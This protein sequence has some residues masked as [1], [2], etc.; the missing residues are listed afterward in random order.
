M[1]LH[2]KLTDPNDFRDILWHP[3]LVLTKV[4]DGEDSAK[5]GNDNYI[6][7]DSYN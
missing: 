6:M 2:A 3:H 7:T 4:S 5:K 1:D